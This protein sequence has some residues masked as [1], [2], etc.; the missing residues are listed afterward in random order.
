MRILHITAL[1]PFTKNSGIPAVL[2]GLTDEQNKIDGVA[3]TVLSLRSE[4]TCMDSDNFYYINNESYSSY[5]DRYQPDIVIFHSFFHV[6]YAFFC[7]EVIKR[8][9]PFFIEPHGA[10]G[11]QA[12]KKSRIKKFFANHTIFLPLINNAKGYIFTNVAEQND[13]I[14][15]TSNDVVI[16][17]GIELNLVDLNYNFKPSVNEFRFYYLGRYDIH[18]KGIDCLLSA[19]DILDNRKCCINFDFYGIGT[20][21]QVEYIRRRIVKYKY[22]NVRECGPVY[23][24][25]KKNVLKMSNILVL[26]SRYEGSPMTVLDALSYGNPCIVTPGTNVADKLEND[27]IGWKVMLDPNSIADKLI[28]ARKEYF[29]D[30]DN[31]VKRSKKYVIKNC[32]WG[33]IAEQSINYLNKTLN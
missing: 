21:E 10:F 3:A 7:Y 9:I 1:S 16:P 13:S 26:T 24:D 8:D 33:S 20:S 5:L 15:S 22:I 29:K 27:G 17:N 31:Y 32:T 19:L 11:K 4:V 25:E 30:Q 18:H 2:K 14:Y 28:V 6:E 12:M 23:E